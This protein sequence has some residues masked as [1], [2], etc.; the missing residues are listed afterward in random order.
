MKIDLDHLL[1]IDAIDRRGSFARAAE[2][3]HRVPSAVTYA[4][5]K[6]E[7]DLGVQI[8]DRSGHRA[9]LTDTGEK[10]LREG[11][12]LLRFATRLEAHAKFLSEGWEPE[13]RIAV[14]DL[15]STNRVNKLVREFFAEHEDRTQIRIS[16]EVFGGCWDAL[17]G[18]RA[19]LVI[20]A[21]LSG[22]PAGG[23]FVTQP[24]GEVNFVFV[25][26]P[27]HPLATEPEPLPADVIKMHRAVAASD[28]SRNLP[29]RTSGILS[30]Q[31]VL[32]VAD[33]RQKRQMQMMGLGVGYLPGYL[34]APDVAAGSLV[35]KKV[36]E[37]RE[38]GPLFIAWRSDFS[39]KAL[40]WFR[41]RLADPVVQGELFADFSPG[42]EY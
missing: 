24:L 35:V 16:R 29:P 5:N 19:D 12:D 28:T 38:A 42:E 14:G 10:V 27:Q 15:V 7:Q 41:R 17:A 6:L 23:G 3:L 13:L 8:F 4:V 33:M 39:G 30:G 18:D 20:G 9:R 37:T 34:V 26:S 1:V 36:E 40:E 21:G 31:D 32:S 22:M 11:R 25:V 2:E